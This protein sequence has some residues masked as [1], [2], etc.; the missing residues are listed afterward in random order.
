M[1]RLEIHPYNPKWPLE[2]EIMAQELTKIW[3]DEL[4]EIHHIGSTSIPQMA[5]KPIID[6]LIVVNSQDK[7][8]NHDEAMTK[9]GFRCRGECLEDLGTKGRFYYSKDTSGIRTHQVHVMELGHPEIQEKINFKNYLI[10]HP[11]DA[12]LY[13]KL[14]ESII[15]K[16]SGIKEYIERKN[17]LVKELMEKANSWVLKTKFVDPI[18]LAHLKKYLHVKTA[19]PK[20]CDLI[21]VF[22]STNNEAAINAI[23]LNKITEVPYIILTGGQNKEFIG[24]EAEMFQ[25]I[26]LQAG[27]AKEKLLIENESK[28]SL[29]NVFFSIP[30]FSDKINWRTIDS[31]IVVSKEYHS[32]RALMTLKKHLPHP[33]KLYSNTYLD[34]NQI[35]N[36][37]LWREYQKIPKYIAQG[38]LATI[39]SHADNFYF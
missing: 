22:G 37:K 34:M 8:T 18:Q 35:D 20:K 7:I 6:I 15:G 3:Q 27:I 2:F 39:F 28:N 9:L 32:R 14:K 19:I 24:T 16:V 4:V 13:Q 23:D 29:E 5:A 33:V 21:F 12:A 25:N 10:H 11:K 1:T 38:D 31:I 17:S 30:K 36:D 26:L